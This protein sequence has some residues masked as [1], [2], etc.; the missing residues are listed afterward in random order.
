MDWMT[1][2]AT[3]LDFGAE[4]MLIQ[5]TDVKLQSAASVKSCRKIVLVQK[6]IIA[7]WSQSIV[8]VRVETHDLKRQRNTV[9]MTQRR[10]L[11]GGI[12]V[13]CVTLPGNTSLVSFV[14]LNSYDK[15]VTLEED[16]CLAHLEAVD[17][18]DE[19][20]S[21][22][23][24]RNEV[25]RSETVDTVIPETSP[26]Y[27]Q[28][29]M[30]DV[31]SNVPDESR[32]GL[33]RLINKYSDI[34]SRSEFDFVETS[35][36]IHR[37]NTGDA[38][39]VR[40]TLRRQPYD[41]VPKIDA[42]VEDLCNAGIFEPSLSPWFSTLVVVKKKDGSYRYC[43]D[44]RKLNSLTR[45]DDYPLPRID[46]CLD[47]FSGSNWF[48]TFDLRAS[49]YQVP[50]HPD[51]A[52]K[53]NFVTRTG[54]YRFKRVPFGLCNAGSMFQRVMDLAVCGMNFNHEGMAYPIVE[55]SRQFE[56]TEDFYTALQSLKDALISAPVLALPRDKGMYVLDT[57][58]SN[59]SIGAVLS[60]M[61]DGEERVIAYASKALSRSERNYCV[62]RRE[63]LRVVYYMQAFRQF[64]LGR[65]FLIRTDHAALQ[66][67]Q[68]TPRTHRPAG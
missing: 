33:E 20:V 25:M 55:K 39:P 36:G 63:M 59:Y 45:R 30:K 57:D 10:M 21:P 17:F 50:M 9:W 6:S 47:T 56:W 64:L 62:T 2:N 19:P 4:F 41:L 26:D 53:T 5:G 44:Y 43:V 3:S 65:K 48:S 32:T 66:W 54:T 38:R 13:R 1:K 24:R 51:D 23:C 68:K 14:I 58:A 18:C 35:L 11:E 8:E 15:P 52:D 28:S 22:N 67:I 31:H 16:I 42:Y 49:Y 7:P 60:Q 12:M 34:F 40:Q 27:I 37:I 46:T 29:M 61:Q